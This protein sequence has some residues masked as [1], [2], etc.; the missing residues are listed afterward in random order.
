MVSKTS[1]R[2]REIP[3][4][5]CFSCRTNMGLDYQRVAVQTMCSWLEQQSSYFK[6]ALVS[7]VDDVCVFFFPRENAVPF[8]VAI[9]SQAPIWVLFI[10]FVARIPLEGH[11]KGWCSWGL[12][13][14]VETIVDS[15]SSDFGQQEGDAP[16]L[17][18]L[19]SCNQTWQLKTPVDLYL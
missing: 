18:H 13:W 11:W 9:R 19:P 4:L 15:D 10:T 7:H 6:H 1:W 12:K 14:L 16:W 3:N 8:S 5:R 17:P 2:Y